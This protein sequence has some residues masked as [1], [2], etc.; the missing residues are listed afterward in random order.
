MVY[1]ANA[2][3]TVIFCKEPTPTPGY[4]L[5]FYM[6]LPLGTH[7]PDLNVLFSA[8]LSLR[9]THTHEQGCLTASEYLFCLPVLVP[10]PTLTS[11]TLLQVA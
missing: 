3:T 8:T 6:T 10:I 5:T 2:K 9:K 7:I 11:P 1:M 4:S